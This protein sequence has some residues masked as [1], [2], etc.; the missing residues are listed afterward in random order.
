MASL[1][2][3][4]ALVKNV[5]SPEGESRHTVL[6][7][8][9]VREFFPYHQRLKGGQKQYSYLEKACPGLG[10]KRS[11]KNKSKQTKMYNNV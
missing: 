7:N 3:S 1:S 2:P 5:N 4:F 8:K 10:I 11:S 9:V 6:Q